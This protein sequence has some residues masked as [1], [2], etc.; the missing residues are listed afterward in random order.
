VVEDQQPFLLQCDANRDGVVTDDELLYGGQRDSDHQRALEC[1]DPI[2]GDACDRDLD[3]IADSGDNCPDHA[4]GLD[5]LGS[6]EP[7]GELEACD[8]TGDGYIFTN[9]LMQLERDNPAELERCLD[10]LNQTC[11]CV[12]KCDVDLNGRVELSEFM[13]GDQSDRD[14]DG[15][16]NACDP[17]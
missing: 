10:L 8:V 6:C 14:W 15:I 4:N 2:Y 13:V 16:G 5:C 1:G 17:D 11:I 9:D 7:V 12:S 3:G